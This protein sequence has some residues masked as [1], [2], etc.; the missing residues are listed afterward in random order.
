MKICLIV[1]GSYP[2]VTGG[3]ASWIQML[4]QGMPEHEFVIYSIAAEAKERGRFQYKLPANLTEV[5]ELFLDSILKLKTPQLNACSLSRQEIDCLSALIRS[6]GVLDLAKLL[7]IFRSARTRSALDIFM[8][9]DF[10]DAIK[11][12]YE[13]KYSDLPFTDFFWTIRSML[14]PL[15][16]LLQ[17]D[18]PEADLY[19][20]V[21]TGY[22]G[23]VGSLAS[24]LYEKPFILTEHGI[25]SRE[26]E[27]ELLKATWV[28]EDFKDLWISYF[29]SLSRLTYERAT[30]VYTLFEKNAEIERYLG[31]APEKIRVI[32]N[33]IDVEKYAALAKK[34]SGGPLTIGTIARVV[35]IKDLLT[36]L[37][38]FA[39]VQEQLPDARFL[40]VG[41][42]DADP[43]YYQNCLE[44]V[45]NLNLSN[46][47][48]TGRQDVAPYLQEIDI[49]VLSSISEGQPLVI[50]EAFAC[51]TPCIATNVGACS[52]LIYGAG[53][54]LGKAG[55]IVPLLDYE[56]MANA[57]LRLASD[58][59]LRRQMG[60]NGFARAASLYTKDLLI[61]RYKKVYEENGMVL[62]QE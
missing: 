44:L 20:S 48:F 55:Y 62:W 35:P 15:F 22:A 45:E 4:I 60:Q 24:V 6:D 19:H 56:T 16:Y 53:D 8:S 41:P 49:L 39:L 40:I 21:A 36:M 34:E 25:Y 32:P 27:E 11:E 12:A 28:K 23:A 46:I 47:E 37:R 5:R 29:Y 42:T 9:F 58:Q 3:V 50:L 43:E 26:R 1:E 51:A 7:P 38:S 10:F 61:Q 17:Q 59:E 54:D 57:I 14:L 30:A 2:Y 13:E 52:E 18:V 33:G 31:C